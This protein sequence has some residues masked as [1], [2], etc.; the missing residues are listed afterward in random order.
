MKLVLL[1][2]TVTCI[3]TGS[4]MGQNAKQNGALEQTIQ[5]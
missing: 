5:V 1:A 2:I 3:V 4:V